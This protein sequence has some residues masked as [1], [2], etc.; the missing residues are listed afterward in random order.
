MAVVSIKIRLFN[1]PKAFPKPHRQCTSFT[2][3]AK[4][5]KKMFS[6]ENFENL[7]K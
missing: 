3:R 1:G 4:I 5:L 7:T 2:Q 6:L